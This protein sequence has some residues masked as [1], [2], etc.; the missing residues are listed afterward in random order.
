MK[1]E[2]RTRAKS[3]DVLI[4]P[5]PRLKGGMW[6]NHPEN[7]SDIRSGHPILDADGAVLGIPFLIHDTAN[8]KYKI[9]WTQASDAPRGSFLKFHLPMDQGTELEDRIY[10][11][12]QLPV[13]HVHVNHEEFEG[14]IT[15]YPM[16]ASEQARFREHRVLL[17]G[18]HSRREL[19][20]LSA[21]QTM[22]FVHKGIFLGDMPK[23]GGANHMPTTLLSTGDALV[24]SVDT[25]SRPMAETIIIETLV[26]SGPHKRNP[27]LNMNS[28]HISALVETL[29]EY[30][31]DVQAL[32][33]M[34]ARIRDQIGHINRT[35]ISEMRLLTAS[36]VTDKP[37]APLK[38]ATALRPN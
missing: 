20:H 32:S 12:A 38:A 25:D 2:F 16:N 31:F 14:E 30:H 37:E 23:L 3:Q 35:K 29:R 5:T 8:N 19:T 4:V 10:A 15:R 26:S 28:G 33:G 24:I 36:E 6:L 22:L 13:A 11:L 9:D 21:E 27:I 17:D 34:P 7:Y 1:A 18:L